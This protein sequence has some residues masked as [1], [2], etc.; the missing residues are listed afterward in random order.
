MIL[1]T[2]QKGCCQGKL[3]KSL[4]QDGQNIIYPEL[5]NWKIIPFFEGLKLY[6][7]TA[8]V[9]CT[10]E[11]AITCRS[12]KLRKAKKQTTEVRATEE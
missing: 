9:V 4:Q 12:V 1:S 11:I 5:P 8:S 3:F 2:S 7:K 6:N 10:F